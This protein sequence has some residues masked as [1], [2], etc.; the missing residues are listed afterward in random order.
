MYFYRVLFK[1]DPY[2]DFDYE[3]ACGLAAAAS[4]GDAVQLICEKY[5]RP[6]TRIWLSPREETIDLIELWSSLSNVDFQLDIDDI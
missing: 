2:E 3:Y 4:Y 5:S 1:P 6:I